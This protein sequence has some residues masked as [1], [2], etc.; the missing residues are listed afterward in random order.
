MKPKAIVVLLLTASILMTSCDTAGLRSGDPEG[1]EQTETTTE[2]TLPPVYD[3]EWGEEEDKAFNEYIQGTLVPEFTYTLFGYICCFGFTD[4]L[5]KSLTAFVNEKFGRDY[6]SVPFSEVDYFSTIT[7]YD[8]TTRYLDDYEKFCRHFIEPGPYYG[9]LN[10]KLTFSYLIKNNIPFGERVS[11]EEIKALLGETYL[12]F[13]RLEFHS[14]KAYLGNYE[15]PY[16]YNNEELAYVLM[17]YNDYVSTL[18]AD[19]DIKT[20]VIMDSPE[21]CEILNGFLKDFF[22]N[23]APQFGQLMTAEQYKE[24]FGEEPVDISNLPEDISRVVYYPPAHTTPKDLY[25]TW[26]WT[27]GTDMI[28]ETLILNEDNTGVKITGYTGQDY[29]TL[30]YS[31]DTIEVKFT[32]EIIKN[33]SGSRWPGEIH[34][35][36]NGTETEVYQYY[37]ED[38]KLY[39]EPK[40]RRETKVYYNEEAKAAEHY[41]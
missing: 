39:M 34:L 24:L 5:N 20:M 26:I 40:N 13:D 31:A 23:S 16:K 14:G 22:G 9:M 41:H 19:A 17:E 1:Q 15:M 38:D 6:E 11:L 29:D 12:C 3:F 21:A 32:Y 7:L 33:S 37:F 18:S 28:N 2:T 10:N 30:V 4:D 36:F 35:T 27:R 25:G 8:T